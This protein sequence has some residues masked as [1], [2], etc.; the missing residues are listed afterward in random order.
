MRIAVSVF[1]AVAVL[2]V[3]GAEP[4]R[5][6]ADD[7]FTGKI[8]SVF[9]PEPAESHTLQDVQVKMVGGNA[10][11][12]GTR[13]QL[14]GTPPTPVRLWYP[15]SHIQWMHVFESKEA[16]LKSYGADWGKDAPK[17][18]EPKPTDGDKRPR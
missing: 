16:A 8:V 18:G 2:A 9:V 7:D 17:K 3:A 10:F 11:L 13:I 6:T 5:P 14:D 15:V 1:A 4:P 12:V